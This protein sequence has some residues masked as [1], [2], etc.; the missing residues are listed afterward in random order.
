MTGESA[1]Q[2]QTEYFIEPK[3]RAFNGQDVTRWEVSTAAGI[4]GDYPSKSAAIDAI[5]ERRA[6]E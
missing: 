6:L 3:V 2:Q 4:I 1:I 5:Q